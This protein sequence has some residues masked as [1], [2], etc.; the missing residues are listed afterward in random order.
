M[1]LRGWRRESSLVEE[2]DRLRLE[3][4]LDRARLEDLRTELEAVRAEAAQLR[5][6]AVKAE[7]RAASK[8]D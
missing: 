4:Q 1:S 8:G 3:S 7:L 6:R 2:R 5:E